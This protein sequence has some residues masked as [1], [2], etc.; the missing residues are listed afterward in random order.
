MT[1]GR[2]VTFLFL[3]LFAFLA[4]WLLSGC[5][6]AKP[7]SLPQADV[8]TVKIPV[9]K[10][11][12]ATEKAVAKVSTAREAVTQGLIYLQDIRPYPEQVE[13][14]RLLKLSL[15]TAKAD[16]AI[17][18]E[19]LAES[20]LAHAEAVKQIEQ[21]QRDVDAMKD[22]GLGQQVRADRAE[23]KLSDMA[24]RYYPLKWIIALLMAGI[25]AFLAFMNSGFLINP[26]YRA[27][28][29]GLAASLTFAAV[30]V[31]L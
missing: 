28:A 17:S 19:Y 24:E 21:K 18:N 2:I 13:T 7:R 15:E 14:L 12:V 5:A 31:L 29:A 26:L 3:S 22:W 30:W 9:E 20:Q 10:A 11:R 8:L 4:I 23:A 27:A 1:P 25:V 16:L 6:S